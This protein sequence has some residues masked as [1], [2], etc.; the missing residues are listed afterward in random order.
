MLYVWLIPFAILILHSF[1]KAL[2]INTSR[3]RL[4]SLCV[5]SLS[6]F[7]TRHC[8]IYI[9]CVCV[10]PR[11][12]CVTLAL[13]HSVSVWHIPMAF[14][15]LFPL[16]PPQHKPQH[17][18]GIP[19]WHRECVLSLL[20]IC[21]SFRLFYISISFKLVSQVSQQRN[22]EISKCL[23][24]IFWRSR[25]QPRVDN[26]WGIPEALLCRGRLQSFKANQLYHVCLVCQ[27]GP[28]QY[29][30]CPV[31]PECGGQVVCPAE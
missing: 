27:M 2:D 20:L 23:L 6:V 28:H 25:W 21:C 22:F 15:G 12:I 11:L 3:R 24:W 14:L 30:L 29:P 26:L 18:P 13:H 16:L 5:I 17:R 9:Y 1:L 10:T 19:K 4:N 31:Y 7:M 8:T